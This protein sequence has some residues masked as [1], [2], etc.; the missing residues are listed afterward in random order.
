MGG[1]LEFNPY[2][3]Q[4]ATGQDDAATQA[5]NASLQASEAGL[6]ATDY[7]RAQYQAGQVEKPYGNN[8]RA[9]YGGDVQQTYNP[10]PQ[11]NPERTTTGN[12]QWR[13]VYGGDTG[14]T[15][16]PGQ[17]QQ[18]QQ[19]QQQDQTQGQWRKPY[20]ADSPLVVPPNQ[21]RPVQERPVVQPGNGQRVGEVDPLTGQPLRRPAPVEGNPWDRPANVPGQQRPPGD[22]RPGMTAQQ[23]DIANKRKIVDQALEYNTVGW[24]GNL[25]AG[26]AGGIL[27]RHTVPWIMDKVSST[28]K[29]DAKAE[30]VT[31]RER[32]VRYWQDNHDP[33]RWNRADL[34]F[35]RKALDGADGLSSK[36]KAFHTP[37]IDALEVATERAKMMEPF[38]KASSV[39]N[40]AEI[41]S[42]LATAKRANTAGR[43]AFFTAEELA[44]MEDTVKTG[45]VQQTVVDAF[46]VNATTQQT[47]K[48]RHDT[49]QFL[50]DA[51]N[52]ISAASEAT[53]SRLR[54]VNDAINAQRGLTEAG[55]KPIFTAKEMAALEEYQTAAKAA[56]VTVGDVTAMSKFKETAGRY[57]TSFIKGASIV[58]V[59]M[60]AD[61]Y[62]DK[63]LFGKN[64][65]NGIGDSINSVLVPAAFL[66]G[67][68]RTLPLIATSVGALLV[69]KTIGA[70]LPE[71]EQ[72]KYSRYFRQSTGES[73]LLG[74]EFLLPMKAATESGLNWKRGLLMA[75]TWGA[76]RLKN[77]IMD[78]APQADVK[79]KAFELLGDDAKK[80]TD[81]SMNDAINKFGEL[82]TGNESTGL[83]AWTNVF[84]DG[85][86]KVQGARGESALQ[87]Y[88]TEWLTKPTNQFG[89]MLEA[90]RGAAILT[91]AFAES[92]LA[93]GTHVPT[94]TD[95]PTYLLEGKNLDIGGKAAR[96]FIIGRINI[97][98]AKKQVQDNLGK[99]IAGKRVEQS[100]IADLDSVKK[101]IEAQ[102]AKIYGEHDMTG[103]VKEL[104]KWGEGLNATH[105]AKL[106]VDLRNTI[107]ANQ[108][109]Q[110][111]RYKAKLYR[112]LA[113]IYLASAYAKQ[114][115]DPQS[116]S[117]LLGGD[118]NSGRM[119]QD[120][121]GQQRG[122]DGALDCIARA[123][124]LDGGNL[125]TKQLYEIAQQI[126]AKLPGNIQKQMTDGKYNPLQIRH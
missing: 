37:V 68:K 46:N 79:D 4:P 58:G 73:V 99:E 12:G 105:M 119:A 121:T 53:P 120:M 59:T 71:G 74:A 57:G 28:V 78:P 90:N 49:F 92:R 11:T 123:H 8:G 9:V 70:S 43:A 102:E 124:A 114:D 1:G 83:M 34:E 63:W 122:F 32:A 45:K 52:P 116:A 66:A 110:D 50:S 72:A 109:S 47:L 29:L 30:P 87:V 125:D 65:G 22:Q 101:R 14:T 93:H 75:G 18:Q 2:E 7:Q 60:V 3:L 100:E 81:G 26:G 94:I 39:G 85:M 115:G 44:M 111:N 35:A 42:A 27:G 13:A 48:L 24:G 108:N 80:R 36:M 96:D 17:Q 38:T 95:T 104:A 5:R 62:A 113:T 20:G 67:P 64:H 77:A 33:A 69:G 91:T 97:E 107:A 25:L 21:Q 55:H 10:G 84:K 51:K 41:E 88:R 76:F 23:Q 56:G 106:E 117:K 6:Q 98:N 86:G 89:S 126:N 19:Q 15:F 82:G 40:V 31:F 54:T 16:R 61:H 112:D 103:A 118:T